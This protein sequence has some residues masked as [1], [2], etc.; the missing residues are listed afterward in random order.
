MSLAATPLKPKYKKCRL[1]VIM[2]NFFFYL[3]HCLLVLKSE[4]QNKM[5][6]SSRQENYFSDFTCR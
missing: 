3:C 1:L 4:I 5:A 2:K 6:S